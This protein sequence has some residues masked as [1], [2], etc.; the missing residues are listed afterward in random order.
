[1]NII[2]TRYLVMAKPRQIYDCI[3]AEIPVLNG[4]REGWLEYTVDNK[5][6]GGSFLELPV[7][8]YE[9]RE[10]HDLFI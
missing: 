4:S 7:A 10:P 6:E 9:S 2:L 5:Q 8:V 1:M 3:L